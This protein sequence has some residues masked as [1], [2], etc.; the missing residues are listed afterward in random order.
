MMFTTS[1]HIT[2]NLAAAATLVAVLA[3]S[4]HHPRSPVAVPSAEA[5]C[6]AGWAA[7]HIDPTRTST[8]AVFHRT[9]GGVAVASDTQEVWTATA[10]YSPLNAAI[11][12]C[13]D[14]S[15][16]VA[17]LTVTNNG[18]GYSI[19]CNVCPAEFVAVGICGSS[20][21]TSGTGAQYVITLDMDH[22]LAGG[23]E[24]RTVT[25]QS[26]SIDD[27]LTIDSSCSTLLSVTPT[28]QNWS[29]TDTTFPCAYDCAYDTSLT[30]TYN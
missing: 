7:C 24:L 21:C 27:G 17:T 18:G 22:A 13:N 6:F 10:Q 16:V 25:F 20:Q 14:P 15:P 12:A 3:V 28:S 29:A 4:Q 5:V 23:F 2:R 8:L 26:T 9:T 11:P 1:H 19:V 30:V